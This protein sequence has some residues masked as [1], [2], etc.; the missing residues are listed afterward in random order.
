M[1][2]QNITF[3][4]KTIQYNPLRYPV[5][6]LIKPAGS[7]CNLDCNYCYYLE[8]NDRYNIKNKTL[9]LNQLEIFTKQYI[10]SQPTQNTL[11]TWHGGE[12]LLMGL[13]YFKKA[14]IIQKETVKKSK[15]VY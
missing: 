2:L 8:K 9:S 12:P 10:E 15:S 13:D 11:F 6:V 7:S 5:Y 4:L 1:T 3:N 14:I